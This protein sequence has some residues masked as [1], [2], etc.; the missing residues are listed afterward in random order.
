MVLKPTPHVLSPSSDRR[1]SLFPILSHL[2]DVPTAASHLPQGLPQSRAAE[3]GLNSLLLSDLKGRVPRGAGQVERGRRS[4]CSP[5]PLHSRATLNVERAHPT[6]LC[7]TCPLSSQCQK[8][9]KP[10]WSVLKP[11]SEDP[12]CRTAGEDQ[13]L[14]ASKQPSPAAHWRHHGDQYTQASVTSEG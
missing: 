1:E 2:P 14:A 6:S 12:H 8:T 13:W 5:G 10:L 3:T 7:L 9:L 11:R 4:S